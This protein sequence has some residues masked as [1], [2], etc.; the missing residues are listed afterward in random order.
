M[1]GNFEYDPLRSS[2]AYDVDVQG[3]SEMRVFAVV[4]AHLDEEGR[5]YVASRLTGPEVVSGTGTLRLNATMRS[6]LEAGEL[7]LQ[8]VTQGQPL[9]IARAPLVLGA[10]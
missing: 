10:P 7:Y 8:L 5:W 1:T 6:R 3:V 2:L 4:L 9:Q